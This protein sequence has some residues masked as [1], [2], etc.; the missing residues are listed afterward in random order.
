[1]ATIFRQCFFIPK[2]SLTEQNL[3]DQTGKV[4]IVTGGYAGCGL[5]LTKI[6]YQ[7]NATV[8]VAGRSPDK[9]AGAISSIIQ[10]CPES[11][12]RLEF[13]KLDLAD[14]ASIKE[15]AEEFMSKEQRLDVLTNNAG[16]MVIETDRNDAQSHD[17]HLGTN[18]LGPF[19]FSELLLPVLRRT[20]VSSPPGSIRVTWASSLAAVFAAPRHGIEFEADGSPKVGDVHTN[21]GI[22]KAGCWFLAAEFARRYGRD[23]IVSNAWN[24]G[25]LKSELQREVGTLLNLLTRI[26]L[27]PAVYGAYTELYAGWSPDLTLENNGA[28]IYPWGRIGT[29]TLRADLIAALRSKE[30]G[31]TGEAGKFWDWCDKETRQ[32]R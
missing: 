19:L 13:L 5:Q 26:L 20:A 11:K 25:N 6:L 31:G 17:I 1:M 16:I 8:Y 9:A 10:Q 29:D 15:S 4:H 7:K 32:F 28:Y 30:D 22:S 23:G 14:Q 27:Y 18:C 3:F 24:P 12:G 21:Y 2:P